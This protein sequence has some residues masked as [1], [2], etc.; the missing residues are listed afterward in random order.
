MKKVQDMKKDEFVR[1]WKLAGKDEMV[2]KNVIKRHSSE[3]GWFAAN[4]DDCDAFETLNNWFSDS[5][6]DNNYTVELNSRI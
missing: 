5:L 6:D 2:A 1:K 3:I 4:C